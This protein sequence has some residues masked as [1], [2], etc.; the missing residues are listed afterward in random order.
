M[1]FKLKIEPSTIDLFYS[2]HWKVMSMLFDDPTQAHTNELKATKELIDKTEIFKGAK[3]LDIG[4]GPGG[5]AAYLA[6]NYQCH[7]IGIELSKVMCDSARKLIESQNLTNLVK[8]IH[9][10]TQKIE[11]EKD[12]NFILSMEV[13]SHFDDK[14]KVIKKCF[15]SLKSRGIFAFTDSILKT[16]EI[17]KEIKDI[18]SVWVSPY[19]E[20]IDG[21]AQ[22]L[23]S[24]G[25]SIIKKEDITNEAIQYYRN[26]NNKLKAL[27]EKIVSKYGEDAFNDASKAVSGWL[28]LMEKRLS[29][30]CRIICKKA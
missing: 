27:K 5:L 9:G 3:V 28:S 4:S 20:T 13:F 16:K 14:E 6:K 15:D 23:K 17:T 19:L 26:R 25:F 29:G 21:Y 12:F 2:A 18:C 24:T 1:K 7:V 30:H 10:D 8:I 11:F 22:I